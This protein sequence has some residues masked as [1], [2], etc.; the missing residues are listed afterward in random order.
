MLP[1]VCTNLFLILDILESGI[2]GVPLLNII[3]RD[4]GDNPKYYTPVIL[5][6]VSKFFRINLC[7][8][9]FFTVPKLSFLFLSAIVQFPPSAA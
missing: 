8:Y 4:R 6:E 9:V 7:H 3:Q 2:F 1:S 5:E